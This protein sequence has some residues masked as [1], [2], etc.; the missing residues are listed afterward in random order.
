MLHPEQETEI[1]VVVGIHFDDLDLAAAALC[2][3]EQ[4]RVN[5][6]AGF[7]PG[8]PECDKDGVFGLQ[9][10]RLEVRLADESQALMGVVQ[11]HVFD[12]CA[13]LPEPF[14]TRRATSAQYSASHTCDAGYARGDFAEARFEKSDITNNRTCLL[15]ES[16]AAWQPSSHGTDKRQPL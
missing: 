13:S 1:R 14:R 4:H 12:W 7:A 16:S 8:R 6:V 15:D 10:F 9:Y 11:V 2:D 3:I 5:D